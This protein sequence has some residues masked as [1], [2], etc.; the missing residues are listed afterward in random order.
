MSTPDLSMVDASAWDEARRC[1]PVIRRLAENPARTR[2]DVVAAAVELGC[3]PTHAYALL[4][5]YLGDARLTSLLPRRR[6]PERGISL[7]DEEVDAVIR[8]VIDTVYLTRQRPRIVHLVEEVRRRCV[9]GGLQVPSRKAITARLQARP[10]REVVAKREGRK[11]V[12]ERYLPAVGSLEAHWP[13]S[14]IQIDHTLVDVIVVDS[15]TRAPIQRPW[16]TLAIDVCTRC[17][18]GFHLSLEPPSATSVALCLAHAALSK[19]GWLAERGIDA[20]WPVRGIPERLHLD[21]AKE[22]RSE[23]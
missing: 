21:N 11:A 5:R 8:E 13:L 22:F 4:R 3:G 15:E 18:A 9:A 6:G 20:A 10:A 16:L 1:L 7:L 19:E 17:V 14:L 23:R 2:G 12:R